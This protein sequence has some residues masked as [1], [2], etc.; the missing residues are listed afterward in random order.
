M[1]L[2]VNEEG[3]PGMQSA[4]D[5]LKNGQN[6]LDASVTGISIVER[7]LDARSVGYGGW[8]NL[9]GDMEFDASVMDGD[10]FETGAVGALKGILSAASVARL[11]KDKSPHQI[12]VGEGASRFAIDN[13][14]KTE[15]RLYTDS[16]SRWQKMLELT[17]SPAQLQ[18][19]PN[20]NLSELPTDA[21]DPEA[22]RDTTIYLCSDEN[23]TLSTVTS[24][25]GWAWKHPGRL[26]D[27]PICGAGFYADS[28]HGAAACTHT[29]EMTIRAG[30][31]HTVVT[32]LKAGNTLVDAMHLALQ[33]LAQLKSGFL[34]GVVIHAMD[35]DAN[36]M[37]AN[38]RCDEA[39]RYWLWTPSMEQPELMDAE[40]VYD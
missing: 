33:D 19:F 1:K 23:R 5:A 13:N 8:P 4:I 6:G 2:L 28:R 16:H 18:Q 27:A 30:T 15:D 39:I 7:S 31:A 14:F 26:G 9:L 22:L 10:T 36:H 35:A 29:G 21:A 20:L 24:T 3:G 12:L 11:V 25:S 40:L 17:L 32:A 34:G 37:V 38:F